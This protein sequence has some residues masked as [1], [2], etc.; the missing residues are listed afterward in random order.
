MLVLFLEAALYSVKLPRGISAE[1]RSVNVFRKLYAYTHAYWLLR[2]RHTR[3]SSELFGAVESVS[4][5]G[6]LVF[7][8]VPGLH[9]KKKSC[10]MVILHERNK[11]KYT[12]KEAID[13]T[14]DPDNLQGRIRTPIIHSTKIFVISCLLMISYMMVN[15]RNPNMTMRNVKK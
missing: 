1:E 10:I 15:I 14:N 13:F 7:E 9:N 12:T 8:E 5:E 2:V 3:A 4:L 6:C 11:E